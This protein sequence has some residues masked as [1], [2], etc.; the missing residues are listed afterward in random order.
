MDNNTQTRESFPGDLLIVLFENP[1]NAKHIYYDL[2]NKGYSKDDITIMMTEETENQYFSDQDISKTELGNKS[3]EGMGVGGAIGGAA[4]A[5]AAGIAALGTSLI[6]PGLG[7]VIAGAFAAAL[8]GAGAGALTGGL[9]GALIGLGVPDKQAKEFEEGI[10]AG[11]VVI[12]VHTKSPEN[13]KLL[14]QQWQAYK[15][16]EVVREDFL[17]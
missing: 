14:N 1:Q 17:R 7:I 9:V 10:K 12:G 3:L 4:G 6:I 15:T 11:G 16:R 13:Y 2:L 5:I 8:A